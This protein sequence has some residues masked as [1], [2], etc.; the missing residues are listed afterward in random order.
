MSSSQHFYPKWGYLS[1]SFHL[2]AVRATVVALLCGAIA[3]AALL[4]AAVT[5]HKF[6]HTSHQEA[7]D[8]RFD[9]LWYDFAALQGAGTSGATRDA[10]FVKAPEPVNTGTAAP[11]SASPPTKHCAQGTWPFF[12]NECL[13]GDLAEGATPDRRRKRIAARLKSPWCSGLHLNYGAY[14]CRPRS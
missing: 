9:E 6:D 2:R 4:V 3:G 12:D 1:P 7:A 11:P 10:G 14:F 13:W 8:P 5:G